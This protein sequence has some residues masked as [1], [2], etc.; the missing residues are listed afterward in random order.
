MSLDAATALV[1]DAFGDDCRVHPRPYQLGYCRPC[2]V[3]GHAS[4][5]GLDTG[6]EWVSWVDVG[7]H[8]PDGPGAFEVWRS[9]VSGLHP[10]CAE[11]IDVASVMN[12]AIRSGS[13]GA[14]RVGRW[15]RKAPQTSS[16]G[17]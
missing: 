2:I 16:T 13:A 1:L 3:C 7:P 14:P 15:T 6:S 17:R 4:V 11:T 8:H 10:W 5:W 9:Q 12:V